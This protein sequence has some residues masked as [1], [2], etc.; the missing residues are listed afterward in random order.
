MKR[1]HTLKNRE[2]FMRAVRAE[3]GHGSAEVNCLKGCVFCGM[4][5]DG[6]SYCEDIWDVM[7]DWLY[8]DVCENGK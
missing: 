1:I 6:G 2:D 8:A 3:C 4:S 5:S 7:A